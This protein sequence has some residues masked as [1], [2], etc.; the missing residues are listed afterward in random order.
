MWR[1]EC[2]KRYPP[3]CGLWWRPCLAMMIFAAANAFT[4]R[5]TEASLS[6]RNGYVRAVLTAPTGKPQE[7]A[8]MRRVFPTAS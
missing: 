6:D 7:A 8:A 5:R 1:S 3:R 4:W 2:A